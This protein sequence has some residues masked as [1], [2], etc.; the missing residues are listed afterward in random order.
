MRNDFEY[1][2]TDTSKKGLATIVNKPVYRLRRLELIG[3]VSL[4][5]NILCAVAF[6]V[7][8]IFGR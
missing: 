4:I 7:M 1:L 3:Y 6:L 8:M 5:V 2:E